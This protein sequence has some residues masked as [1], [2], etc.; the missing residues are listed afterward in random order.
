MVRRSLALIVFAGATLG[1]FGTPTFAAPSNAPTAVTGTADCGS[2]GRF[3]FVVNSGKTEQTTLSP[4]FITAADGTTALFVPTS[5]ELTVV[6][7]GQTFTDSRSKQVQGDVQCAI[8]GS[9]EGFTFSGTAVGF[10]RASH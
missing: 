5:L 9:G 10:V 2:A 4:A 6:F 3:S 1:V 7:D 8:S